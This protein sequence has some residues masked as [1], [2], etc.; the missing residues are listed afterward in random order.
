MDT[1]DEGAKAR[2]KIRDLFLSKLAEADQGR[3]RV[4]MLGESAGINKTD[5]AIEDLFPDDFYIGLVNRAY[6]IS[7]VPADLPADGSD[8]IVK[9]IE[10][11]LR[12]KYKYS[13]L[14][15]QRVATELLRTF[16]GW[17]TLDDIPAG[18]VERAE[19]LFH[20]INEAFAN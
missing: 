20:R 18:T 4:F 13:G 10:H 12:T 16:D 11:V 8:M 5:A 1:D 17:N 6:G 14:D 2:D 9:R 19:R 7:I 15:M 3:F